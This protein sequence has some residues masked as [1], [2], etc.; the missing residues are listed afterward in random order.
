MP[1]PQIP[2]STVRLHHMARHRLCEAPTG[3]AKGSDLHQLMQDLTFVQ[4][5]SINTVSRAHHMILHARRTNYRPRALDKLMSD[6]LAFEHWTH[7]ASLIEM[8]NFAHWKL[9][10]ARDAVIVK[11][12]YKNW[13][14][15]GYEEKFNTVLQH[16]ADN[17]PCCSSDVGKDEKKGSGGWWDWHP[18]KTALEYLW[19]A[20]KLSVTHRKGFRKFY[21]LTERVIP[22]AHLAA[23]FTPEETIDHACATALDK[24]GFATSGEIAAF[25]DMITPAEAKAWCAAQLAAGDLVEVELQTAQ[26]GKPRRSFMRPTTLDTPLPE[27]TK[28]I[29]ILS[30]FDPALRDR[31][32][33]ERLFGFHYRIEVFVPAPKRQY[34]Y[35]VF[36]V[37]EGD[38]LIGRIDM[39]ADRARDT[40]AVRAFWPES[41][42]KL[43]TGRIKALSTAIER[44]TRL[45]D[46]TDVD[47]AADW[48]R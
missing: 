19:R 47:Y 34:G 26:G 20:G 42:V 3:T 33:T 14:R 11:A 13:R 10:F 16:I 7:D 36:P 39:K 22:K 27:P 12:R 18:S 30:P 44:S 17:G 43:G 4:L 35:Y 6:R 38:R 37:L 23:S 24:L 1:L 40:M 31:K 21:D 46:V 15:D 32:R 2:L 5:D 9:K 28:R 41:G 29:R 48:L 25:W 8:E 45:A